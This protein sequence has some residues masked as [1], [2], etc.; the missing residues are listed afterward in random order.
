MSSNTSNN[1]SAA[2][3]IW[4]GTPV[5]EPGVTL[6]PLL[7]EPSAASGLAVIICPGGSYCWL[8]WKT[9]G[10]GV[11]RWL[12]ANGIAAFVLRYRVAGYWSFVTHDRLVLRRRQYPDMLEDVQRAIQVVREGAESFRID[13]AKVG[14]MGFSAGGHL[15]LMAGAFFG[16]NMLAPHG[17]A[18]NVPLRP[19]FIAPIYP[20]VTMSDRRCVHRRSRR[21][22]LGEWRKFDRTW[23][24]ELSMER[25]ATA[26]MPPVFLMNCVDDPVVDYRNSEL[27][28]DALVEQGVEHIYIQYRTGGHGFGATPAKT[29]AEAIAWR[30][31]FLNWV[32][33]L[34]NQNR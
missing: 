31:A 10:L 12:Q 15:S 13:P 22:M 1:C 33:T 21:G 5:R 27:L 16:R 29:S 7:P 18:C 3:P 25:Q 17:I 20:V 4:A 2:I 28:R 6:T 9:E 14:V 8:D 11:A 19:D 32:T 24:E 34:F 26:E 30:E 23:R